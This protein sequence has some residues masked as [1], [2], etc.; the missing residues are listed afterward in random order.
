VEPDAGAAAKA[1]EID[2]AKAADPRA[3]PLDSPDLDKLL[4]KRVD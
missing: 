4:E 2:E 1:L 3:N